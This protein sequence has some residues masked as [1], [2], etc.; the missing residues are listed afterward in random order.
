MRRDLKAAFELA[1][2]HHPV[3]HYKQILKSFQEEQIAQEEARK[4]AAATPKKS[5]KGKGKA[6]DDDEDADVEDADVAPKSAKSKKRKAE[7]DASVSCSKPTSAFP[8]Q[9]ADARSRQTPQRPDSV[10]K[11]KIKLNTSSTPKTAN[12]AATPNFAGGAA[13]KPSKAKPKKAKEGGENKDETPKQAKMSTEE[14]RAR[15]EVR[16]WTSMTRG[17]C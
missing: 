9:M 10:K 15:K 4:Q 12:G 13:V 7:E 3:E 1:A 5:K 11:P 14:R 8:D 17:F 16:A 2:E 6:A